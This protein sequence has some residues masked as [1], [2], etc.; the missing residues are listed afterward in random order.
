MLTS[1][2]PLSS[3]WLQNGVFL[4][5]TVLAFILI[6]LVCNTVVFVMVLIQI[7]QMRANKL[8]AGD[9]GSLKDLRAVGSLTVLL[10][11]SWTIGFLSHGPGSLVLT[12]LFCIFNTLQ[13]KCKISYVECVVCMLL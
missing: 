6:I 7:R 3:C 9:H 10:G 2:I 13:G 5:T 12:Y 4:Y 1:H 11:L 8:A